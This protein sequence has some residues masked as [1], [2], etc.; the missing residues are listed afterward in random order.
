MLNIFYKIIIARKLEGGDTNKAKTIRFGVYDLGI[1]TY[2]Q[3][4]LGFSAYY[5]SP[6]MLTDGIN[7]RPLKFG[8]LRIIFLVVLLVFLNYQTSILKER[9]KNMGI[10]SHCVP[11]NNANNF[12]IGAFSAAAGSYQNFLCFYENKLNY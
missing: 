5:V 6:Y 10:G 2:E 4:K 1:V 7:R 12:S 9:R 11:N 8:L 3:N